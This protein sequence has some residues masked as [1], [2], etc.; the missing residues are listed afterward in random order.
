M[1]PILL[2]TFK[3]FEQLRSTVKALKNNIGALDSELHIFSDG[4]I[5]ENDV[6]RINKVRAFL[7]TI[8]GFKKI[9]FHESATHKGLA[10][11]IIDG[12]TK[13]LEIHDEVIV[14]EDD[15]HT[16][17]NFLIYMNEA[18]K[19]Y[20]DESAVF[21]VSG[22]SLNLNGGENDPNLCYFLNRGWSWGWGTW[23]DR[24]QLADWD[25]RNYETFRSNKKKR[26]AFAEGGSD[27]NAMLDKQ[28]TGRL[29]SWAIRWYFTQFEHKGLTLYPLGSKVQNHGFDEYA[30]HTRGSNRRYKPYLDNSH[31]LAFDFPKE[32]LINNTFQKRFTIKMGIKARMISKIETF[33]EYFKV[34][35]KS[36]L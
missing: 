13:I 3:R 24:W 30:T 31:S 14:L 8:D 27:L 11:S 19:T 5:D 21:S 26:R 9:Y 10:N 20:R 2:F 25:M 12:V 4:A 29:D 17:P 32:I 23:K 6:K 22:Y 18:L 35:N 33:L 1:A 15:L 7:K 28:M 16:T 36:V 34:L